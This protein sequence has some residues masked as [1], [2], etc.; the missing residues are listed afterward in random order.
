MGGNALK[1][2]C[3]TRRF[4]REEYL[5]IE[6]E[7][8]DK[9]LK[10]FPDALIEPVQAYKTKPSFGDMDIVFWSPE[11]IHWPRILTQMFDTKGWTKNGNVYSFE[12]KEM[13]IDLIITSGENFFP[14]IF[15]FAYNDLGNLM[16]RIS[17]KMGFKYGH[18]GLKFVVRDGDYQFAEINVS[19]NSKDIFEFLGYSW[20]RYA[21]GFDT[22]EDIFEYVTTSPFFNKDIYLLHNRNH[23]SR[24][25]DK[26]RKTY[27]EFLEWVKDKTGLNAYPWQSLEE[28]GGTKEVEE[29]MERAFAQWPLFKYEYES[30]MVRFRRHQ[31]A[32]VL[33]N[34]DLVREWTGM[35]G[36]ELGKVMKEVREYMESQ[37]G[38]VV[39]FVLAHGQDYCKKVVLNKQYGKLVPT[40]K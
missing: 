24:V 5:V 31:R 12:Y 1:D 19:K 32:K 7:V 15:Y 10:A 33:F 4:D 9:L 17:H 14:S 3:Y 20:E 27:N 39:D 16:G 34:G 21:E 37:E 8:R 30:T 38:S 40:N 35:E 29:F 18:D 25:R 23:T 2:V 11:P 6:K 13:Q 26:K 28:R 22:L 36:P